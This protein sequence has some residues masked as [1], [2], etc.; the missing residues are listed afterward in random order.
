[1]GSLIDD[2]RLIAVTARQRAIMWRGLMQCL[3]TKKLFECISGPGSRLKPFYKWVLSPAS[4]QAGEF[5]QTFMLNMDAFNLIRHLPILPGPLQVFRYAPL[6]KHE[7]D[8]KY[9]Q[10]LEDSIGGT[11]IRRFLFENARLAEDR[12]LSFLCVQVRNGGASA[13]ITRS[14]GGAWGTYACTR[15]GNVTCY[16]HV[17]ISDG[18]SFG[19]LSLSLS[20]SLARACPLLFV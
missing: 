12:F 17:R 14:G 15:G 7:V 8:I 19:H 13:I 5:E 10:S 20:L 11:G 6:L 2:K 18:D 1:M 9:K 16:I 4:I 3:T